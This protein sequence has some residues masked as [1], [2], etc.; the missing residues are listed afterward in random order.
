MVKNVSSLVKPGGFKISTS[1]IQKEGF[2]FKRGNFYE[3]SKSAKRTQ[4]IIQMK[5]REAKKSFKSL[6]EIIDGFVKSVQ[7]IKGVEDIFIKPED[8]TEDQKHEISRVHKG[9]GNAIYIK[10]LTNDDINGIFFKKIQFISQNNIFNVLIEQTKDN[11]KPKLDILVSIDFSKVSNN[12]V[13]DIINDI[14]NL[15]ES[16]NKKFEEILTKYETGQ[17]NNDNYNADK[18]SFYTTTKFISSFEN[19]LTDTL[20]KVANIN[21]VNLTPNA[22]KKDSVKTEQTNEPKQNDGSNGPRLN[23]LNMLGKE[24]VKDKATNSLNKTFSEVRDENQNS[25]LSFGL[26]FFGILGTKVNEI[27]VETTEKIEK[28]KDLNSTNAKKEGLSK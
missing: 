9:K 6:D 23:A 8:L 4:E 22:I 12:N 13:V 21:Y 15:F 11:Q 28:A 10:E 25:R 26:S 18:N 3:Y 19:H 1:I 16:V 20:L 5:V 17:I 7:H 2:L 14:S 24:E 27:K